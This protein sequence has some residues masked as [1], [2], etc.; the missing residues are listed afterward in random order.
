MKNKLISMTDF[1][2]EQD[3]LEFVPKG[4]DYADEWSNFCLQRLDRITA[5]ANFLKQP[6][7]LWMFVPCDENGKPMKEGYEVFDEDCTEYDEYVFKYQKAK[8][9]CLFEG[10]E[11]CESQSK[12]TILGIPLSVSPYTDSG[13]LYVTKKELDGYHTWFHLFTIEDLIQCN[14][15]RT[16]TAINQITK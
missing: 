15:T 11:Y 16:Q 8:E 13:R 3:K 6:L 12:A 1:V 7:E 10:F 9:R 2:L 4:E 14:L 5:Y